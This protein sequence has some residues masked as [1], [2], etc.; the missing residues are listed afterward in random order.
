MPYYFMKHN[1][2]LS[3]FLLIIIFLLVKIAE[4]NATTSTV[5][6]NSYTTS[7]QL[8][9]NCH[10]LHEGKTS[11]F[12]T[13]SLIRYEES[14]AT[15]SGAW[16]T[17]LDVNFSKGSALES[18][19]TGAKVTFRYEEAEDAYLLGAK[20]PDKGVVKLYRDGEYLGVINLYNP[21]PVYQA[22]LYSF[23]GGSHE[24]SAVVSSGAVNIDSFEVKY[25]K[26]SL[27][28]S[29]DDKAVCYTCHNGTGGSDKVTEFGDLSETT[30]PVS[31]HPVPERKITCI[32]CHSPHKKVENWDTSY[33]SNEV[34][35]L[36]RAVFHYFLG[37]I[38]NPANSNWVDAS[39]NHALRIPE[40][41]RLV[42]SVDFCGAC[43]GPNNNLKGGDLLTYYK[44]SV[45]DTTS[46][47]TPKAKSGISCFT[48]HEWHASP[49]MPK[50]LLEN[51]NSTTITVNDN[52]VCYA[53]HPV[54]AGDRTQYYPFDIHGAA[55]STETTS[56]PGLKPPYYYRLP[57]L[58]CVVC[59]NPH[60]SPNL[61]W[62]QPVVEGVDVEIKDASDTTGIT[63]FCTACHELSYT[64]A[65][66]PPDGCFTCHFH[67]ANTVDTDTQTLF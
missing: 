9:E 39:P 27:L 2:K 28:T 55:E 58:R 38:I 52:G 48:C 23:G 33:E 65:G 12:K 36:L 11:S 4:A 13:S 15:K 31:R 44:N 35:R 21:V 20:G 3:F 1:F 10:K 61:S 63:N 7:S 24:M 17:L 66:N 57:E 6:H 67:G 50:L 8:C 37:Y 64:H 32:N 26:I 45:H 16:S 18:S 25:P 5:P 59:H 22:M 51:I 14:S 47:I 62:I 53:C 42:K 19:S 43:H 49:G 30:P 34:V 54:S 41:R 29:G 60:G 40:Q 56:A 46:T